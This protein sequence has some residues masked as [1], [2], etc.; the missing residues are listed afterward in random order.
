MGK[1]FDIVSSVSQQLPFFSCNNFS[2]DKNCQKDIAKYLYC[3][4]FNVQPFDGSFGKQPKKWIDKVNTI[5]H[6]IYER[7]KNIQ[8]K[9]KK[10]MESK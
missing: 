2:I 1:N 3:K 7:E 8:N 10:K 9:M 5:K 4:E 6:C